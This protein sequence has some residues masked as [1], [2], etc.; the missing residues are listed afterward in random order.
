MF[1]KY[2][3]SL[4]FGLL[5][6]LS[7][8]PLYFIVFLPI[9]LYYILNK[10]IDS[11][12]KKEAF[13][14]GLIFGFGYYLTQLYWIS[15]ALLVDIKSFFWLMPFAISAIPLT[16]AF[17]I[18]FP[19]LLTYLVSQ[20]TNNRLIISIGFSLFYVF[21][22]YIRSFIFPWNFFSYTI[23]FSDTLPQFLAITNIYTFDFILIF[24]Y[25]FLFILYKNKS[26]QNKKYIPIFILIPIFLFSFGYIRLKNAKIT[27]PSKTFRMVQANIPQTLKWDRL[28]T[29]KNL[30]K[31]FDLTLSDGFDDIDIVV[32]AESSIPDIL[33]D[34][35]VLN[36]RFLQLKDKILITGAI[37]GEV[38]NNTLDKMFN[39]IFII[40][41]GKILNY[42]DKSILVPFGEFI[43][44]SKYLPFVKKITQGSMEFSKGSGNQTINIDGLKVSPIICYEVIFPN[45]IIDKNNR[46]DIIV[47]LTNDGWFGNSSGP[48]QH[49]IATKF[50]AIENQLPIVRV[51][52]SGITAYINEYGVITKKISLSKTGILDY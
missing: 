5:A 34:K 12:N 13:I 17:F 49:L 28:E 7:F 39:S 20:K 15:F 21:F 44:F 46:P 50:R 16:C 38:K 47:N 22:E 48:Y 37:R 18:A 41:N 36:G 8:P 33:T 31:H 42:Y 2:K 14:Y 32:W 35:S 45:N 40:Q 19:F 6:G 29:E 51:S 9:S 52:N 24:F 4:I 43:P 26:F 27:K 25:C 30:D 23:G 11:Q 3:F 1:K 10:T